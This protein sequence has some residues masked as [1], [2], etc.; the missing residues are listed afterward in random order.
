[1]SLYR[2]NL[3]KYSSNCYRQRSCDIPIG[4]AFN[5][6]YFLTSLRL[7]L[8]SPEGQCSCKASLILEVVSF[9]HRPQEHYVSI[10]LVDIL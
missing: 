8:L 5:S 6:P 7:I 2:K 9:I 4:V 3:L 10:D 1:M